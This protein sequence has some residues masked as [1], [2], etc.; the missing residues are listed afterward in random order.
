MSLTVTSALNRQSF[1][2]YALF[3]LNGA[4]F[5][6][7]ASRLPDIRSALGLSL[8]HLGLLLL[9]ASLASVCTLPLS[10]AVI[11]RLGP[12][13]TERIGLVL[14]CVGLIGAGAAT[15][16][17][18]EVALVVPG[19]VLIGI[20]ISLWDVTMNLQG[21]TVEKKL[22]HS[23]MPRYHAAF[24]AGTVLFALIGAAMTALHVPV[25]VHLVITSAVVFVVGWV[26][27]ARFDE[28]SDEAADDQVSSAPARS[29]WLEPRTLAIGVV[30]LIAAFTEGTANDWI[31]IAMV[32]G[33]GVPHWAGV[34]GFAIFLGFM[35]LA[36]VFGTHLLDRFGRVAMLRMLFAI[37]LVGSLL[38]VFGNT[39]LAYLGAMLWGVGASMGFPVGISAATDD[40][41]RA[42]ARLS[43][44]TTIGYTAFLGGPPLLGLLGEHV[45]ILHA[46]LVIGIAAVLAL[47]FAPATAPRTPPRT[48]A[49]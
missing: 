43:V 23:I 20:G 14:A 46:L 28:D 1:A 26:Y 45:G 33:H 31:S 21:A 17:A 13:R 24:S 35:T 34:L 44:V 48:T 37:A 41:T 12:R 9:V 8:A 22:G 49:S 6:S 5:A 4:A 16:L 29:A 39:A 15:S 30:V 7:W 18:G 40:P 32:D 3:L 25:G 10:G 27:S 36:R 47:A 2:V 42:T 19:M 11:R 38:V